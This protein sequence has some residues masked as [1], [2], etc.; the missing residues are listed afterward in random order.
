MQ[1]FLLSQLWGKISHSV[2]N[3]DLLGAARLAAPA[4]E[5]GSGAFSL[6]K[7]RQRH[8][9]DKAPLCK[10]MLIVQ[11]QREGMSKPWGQWSTQ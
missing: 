10:A 7:G 5:A 1:S 6:R 9:R 4:A 2:G 3:F 11:G 8:W